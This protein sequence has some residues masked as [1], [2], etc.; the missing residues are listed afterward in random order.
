MTL[1]AGHLVARQP[2]TTVGRYELCRKLADGG[3]ATVYLARMLGPAGFQ[4][5]VAL[6]CIHPH[7]VSQADFL[8]RFYD[9]ARLVSRISHPN[10][11]SVLDFGLDGGV[12]YIALELLLG[13][14]LAQMRA[15]QA[16]SLPLE[17]IFTVI[18]ATSR[19]LH[20]AHELTGTDGAR[21]GVVHRDVSPENIFVT[22]D[23]DIKLIDFGVA[24]AGDQLHLTRTRTVLGKFS[25]MS[26]EQL[27]GEPVDR[28]AD[29]WAIGVIL[30][31]MLTRR[32][33]FRRS[34]EATTAEAVLRSTIVPPS[35]FAN[36]PRLAVFDDV[37]QKALQRDPER[38]YGS[39]AELADDLEAAGQSG[40]TRDRVASFMQTEFAVQ[41]AEMT[42]F[43][44]AA[45]TMRPATPPPVGPRS[46]M[47]A[48]I[49][50]PAV[51]EI[52][53]DP[54]D[55]GPRRG[56][57]LAVIG[58]ATVVA[59]AVVGLGG[60]TAPSAPTAPS[61]ATVPTAGRPADA[62]PAV[63]IAPETRPTAV[64]A[65]VAPTLPS[66]SRDATDPAPPK[67][68]SGARPAM[69]KPPVPKPRAAPKPPPKRTA[70]AG[71]PPKPPKRRPPPPRA[72]KG[73]K[74]VAPRGEGVLNVSTPGGWA[75]VYV[76]GQR[77]GRSPVRIRVPA[78]DRRV[79]LRA[80]GQRTLIRQIRV[81]DRDDLRVVIPIRSTP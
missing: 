26:P 75:D 79:E 48:Q 68:Q 8:E 34:T 73:R 53:P 80:F 15:D 30:W 9:E 14:T 17:L 6:K 61:A 16:P 43:A 74:D 21:L 51:E 45:K 10:V 71:S 67:A 62:P 29:V 50:D 4:K 35:E 46:S 12:Y 49:V 24:K 2:G 60:A 56:V 69:V 41:H 3:M 42:G 19:G 20:A 78:G 13:R 25:Y 65:P 76:D 40:L 37:A 57:G 11:C 22:F 70:R 72:P 58:F 47:T 33:L 39:A 38:R 5:L 32:R 63:P 7:L 1:L 44:R 52:V 28:R 23:G 31:E 18:A 27:R 81:V 54:A 66:E 77:H 55:R 64:R 59:A 36:D